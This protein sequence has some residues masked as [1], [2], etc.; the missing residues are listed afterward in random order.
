M[1]KFHRAL[2][3][4]Q[5]DSPQRFFGLAVT[6]IRR[7]L[8]DLAR[9]HFGPEGQAANHETN[10]PKRH[11]ADGQRATAT[12]G[13]EGPETIEAWSAFHT[14]VEKLPEPER[15]AFQL[16]WYGG[17]EQAAAA[18]VLDVSVSTIQRRWYRA[19]HLLA[20]ALSAFNSNIQ[21]A[22]THD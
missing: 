15:E 11:S 3:A 20:N 7:S 9:H 18:D 5:P 14:A 4:V 13:D 17:L 22:N 1:V 12:I 10:L 21:P 19:R 16:I 6:Q 8:I 2:Q